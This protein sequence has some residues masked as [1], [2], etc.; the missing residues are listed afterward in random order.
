MKYYL[1]NST[2]KEIKDILDGYVMMLD[3][4][5]NESNSDRLLN[6]KSLLLLYNKDI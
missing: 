5:T 4:N 6:V 1:L 2:D 3:N